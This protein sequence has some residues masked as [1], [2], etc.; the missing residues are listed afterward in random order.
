MKRHFALLILSSIIKL[1]VGQ[2]IQ[3]GDTVKRTIDRFGS[4]GIEY[5][6]ESKKIGNL[7]YSDWNNYS[8]VDMGILIRKTKDLSNSHI[9]NRWAA[10]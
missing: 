2:T 6:S 8:G 10:M 5:L 7:T 3:I 4:P 1:T 9:E